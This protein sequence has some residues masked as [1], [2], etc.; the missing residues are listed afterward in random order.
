MFL[1]NTILFVG[2]V[3]GS[4][5][6]AAGLRSRAVALVLALFSLAFVFFQHSFFR[7]VWLEGGDWKY[8]EDMP[9]PK[10]ALPEDV[11]PTDLTMAEILDLHRYYFFLGLS[12]SGALL[13]LAQFGPGKLAVQNSEVILPIRAQD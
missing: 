8:D 3:A 11:S 9:M 12:S 10:V 13:L 6:V 1:I 2:L 4:A 5:L 7:Y